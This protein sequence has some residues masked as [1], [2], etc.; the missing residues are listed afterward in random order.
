[1]ITLYKKYP[2]KSTIYYLIVFLC[3]NDNTIYGLPWDCLNQTIVWFMWK[4]ILQTT[5][6]FEDQGEVYEQTF[7]LR[8]VKGDIMV[9][10]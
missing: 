8:H 1:M 2:A 9:R 10:C 3:F 7:W 4:A 5:N 6:S